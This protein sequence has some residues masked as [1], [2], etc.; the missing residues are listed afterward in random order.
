MARLCSI[1]FDKTYT[2]SWEQTNEDIQSKLLDANKNKDWNICC[3]LEKMPFLKSLI[4]YTEQVKW[5][6]SSLY[7]VLEENKSRYKRR[8]LAFQKFGYY[9]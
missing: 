7:K 5:K 4:I 9:D 6:V 1:K 2:V 8:I 3:V